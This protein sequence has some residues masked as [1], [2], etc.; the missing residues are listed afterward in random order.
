MEEKVKTFVRRKWGCPHLI[1]SAGGV[2]FC[3]LN[4]KTCV[5]NEKKGRC[6]TFAK[7][8]EEWKAEMHMNEIDF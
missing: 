8:I 1:A 7:I 4:T 2:D 3:E 6:E 5:Y